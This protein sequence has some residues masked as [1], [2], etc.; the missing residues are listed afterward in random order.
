VS[1]CKWKLDSNKRKHIL[2]KNDVRLFIWRIIT[3]PDYNKEAQ[4]TN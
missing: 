4:A 3:R 1:Q 2:V